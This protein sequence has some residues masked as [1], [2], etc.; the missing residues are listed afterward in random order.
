MTK[1]SLKYWILV[2]DCA[3]LDLSVCKGSVC[4]TG[5]K[6][7]TEKTFCFLIQLEERWKIFEIRLKKKSKFQDEKLWRNRSGGRTG[8]GRRC[9]C[10][11]QGRGHSQFCRV[12]G[13][14]LWC[15]YS[16]ITVWKQP[17]K[18]SRFMKINEIYFQHWVFRISEW[19]R[20][21]FAIFWFINLLT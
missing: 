1:L 8:R 19:Q 10:A 11:V 20:N 21:F 4:T 9:C 3:I 18:R 15:Y 12:Q 7:I 17:T 13:I 5:F 16:L 6:C 2:C 14:N